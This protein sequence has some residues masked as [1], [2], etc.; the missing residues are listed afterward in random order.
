MSEDGIYLKSPDP[1]ADL[2]I[3]IGDMAELDTVMAMLGDVGDP[4]SALSQAAQ[5]FVCL[6]ATGGVIRTHVDDGRTVTIAECDLNT[7]SAY[8]TFLELL[9]EYGSTNGDIEQVA[10]EVWPERLWTRYT[11]DQQSGA[12]VRAEVESTSSA[13]VRGEET[14]IVTSARIDITSY[15]QPIEFPT[16]PTEEERDSS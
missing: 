15:N 16:P 13:P 11:F 10:P 7:E 14:V 12:L 2:W 3:S 4:S 5:G 1:D 8:Q 9:D 6:E